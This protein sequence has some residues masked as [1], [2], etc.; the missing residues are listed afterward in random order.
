[1][2]GYLWGIILAATTVGGLF[3]ALPVAHA[4]YKKG[5]RPSALYTYLSGATVFRIPMIL[6]EASFM[7]MKFTIIRMAIALPLI[8]LTS[9]LLE[10]IVQ[11]D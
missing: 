11:I 8:I 6:F 7:G 2:K 3:V 5:A 9:M 10:R 1:L 4:L